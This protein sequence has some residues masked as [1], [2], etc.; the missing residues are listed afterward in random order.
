M[1]ARPPTSQAPCS[2][3]EPFFL[4]LAPCHTRVPTHR[5][6]C[7][8]PHCCLCNRMQIVPTHVAK[9]NRYRFFLQTFQVNKAIKPI[10][11]APVPLASQQVRY[12]SHPFIFPT[13]T[14]PT[15]AATRPCR[16][17]TSERSRMQIE[18]T[19]AELAPAWRAGGLSATSRRWTAPR[20]RG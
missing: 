6:L 15:C 5:Y 16:F 14:P 19:K 9:H 12:I 10:L 3:S 7:P 17:H 20:R 13:I 1:T 8:P 18:V 2:A 11:F 4:R